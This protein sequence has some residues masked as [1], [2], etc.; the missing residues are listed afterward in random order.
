M[1]NR[2]WNAAGPDG[3]QANFLKV[4][5]EVAAAEVNYVN[6]K[7]TVLM[8]MCQHHDWGR[9]PHRA[10]VQ[11]ECGAGRRQRRAHGADHGR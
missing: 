10:R 7:W 9:D 1:A 6:D 4:L 5:E 2:L 8:W 3:T 11:R